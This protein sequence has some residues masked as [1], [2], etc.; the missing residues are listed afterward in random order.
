MMVHMDGPSHTHAIVRIV[1]LGSKQDQVRSK[2]D[3][4]SVD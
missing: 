2:Q 3:Q 1:C 4:V